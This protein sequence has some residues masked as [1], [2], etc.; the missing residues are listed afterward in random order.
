VYEQGKTYEYLMMEDSE[1][2]QHQQMKQR[3][4]TEDIRRLRMILNCELH[5][6]NRIIAIGK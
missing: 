6:M 2:I 3:M 4:K 5:D 1:G